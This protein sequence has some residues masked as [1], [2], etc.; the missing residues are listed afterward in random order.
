MQARALIPLKD[1]VEAKS[2]LSGVLNPAERRALAQAMVEDVLSVLAGHP[3]IS[4]LTLVSDDPGANMLAAKYGMRH[5]R[6]SSLGCR[7]LNPVIAHCCD[8]LFL[9]SDQPI[10]VLHGD[11]PC[12]DAGDITAVLDELGQSNGLVVGCDRHQT[13]TNLLAFG[14]RSR[15]D[16]SFGVDSCARHLACA[17]ELG[18]L[19]LRLQRPGIALDIDELP[20][21]AIL[22]NEIELGRAGY[23]A[24]L[25]GNT[26][27]GN[28]IRM[29][30]ASLE[31][32]PVA[33]AGNR[34]LK[35]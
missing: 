4:T 23:C 5:W 35:A 21:L 24:Q 14:P 18:I 11:L 25:L 20:D 3:E 29:Q 12:L 33:T 31:P 6:E 1:L 26:V 19:A 7:G 34:E 16:F 28:R 32:R 2:R 22:L 10:I 8:L 13:G 17:R 15:I 30:L 27:L 9:E